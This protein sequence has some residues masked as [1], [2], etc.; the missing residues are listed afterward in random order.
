MPELLSEWTGLSTGL[1]VL[2]F[3]TALLAG[4]I[5]T[6]AGG[7]GLI[8]LPALILAGLPPLTA[9]GVNKLQGSVG[10]AT[11]SWM[12]WR[13]GKLEQTRVGTLMA[14]AFAGSVA[15]SLAIQFVDSQAL[16]WVIPVVLTLIAAWF[17]LAPAMN[18]QPGRARMGSK[19]YHR[20]VIPLIG[21]Y[22]GA[23]GPGT[24]SFFTL[25]GVAL[26]GHGL[27]DSTAIAKTLNFATNLAALLVFLA[28]GQVLWPVGLLMMAGQ[29]VGA[30]LGAHS[31]LRIDPRWLRLLIVGTSLAMLL[32]YLWQ[33]H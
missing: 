13:K 16:R 5:D 7:G 15:G 10:T 20:L 8:T 18:L 14:M 21:A 11:A 30:W 6:L 12:M 31:L 27:I 33:G 26:R 1:L 29:L 17:L 3:A 9:L 2:L 22:D 24:G 4:F 32:R 25:A 28:A 19:S 23:F